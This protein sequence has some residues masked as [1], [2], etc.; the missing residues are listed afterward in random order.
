MFPALFR[1]HWYTFPV[2]DFQRREAQITDLAAHVRLISIGFSSTSATCWV[3]YSQLI[4]YVISD[5][6]I[7][8]ITATAITATNCI[9]FDREC[10]NFK[11]KTFSIVHFE[12]QHLVIHSNIFCWTCSRATVQIIIF[13]RAKW[14]CWNQESFSWDK[15]CQIRMAMLSYHPRDYAIGLAK[16]WHFNNII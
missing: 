1:E 10:C 3:L 8:A 6:C 7:K 11:P 14:N 4:S 2:Y 9:R 5:I 15:F 13:R 16:I 12:I